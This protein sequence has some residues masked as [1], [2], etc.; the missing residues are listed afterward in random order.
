M[1]AFK[2]G[3]KDS[4]YETDLNQSAFAGG[5]LGADSLTVD[6]GGFLV[7]TQGHAVE[8]D[9]FGP[10]TLNI[11]GTVLST[12]PGF[13]GI[14]LTGSIS[15]VTANIGAEGF[16]SGASA[17]LLL[18]STGTQTITNAGTVEGGTYGIATIG[19]TTITNSGTISGGADAINVQN[20]AS[21]TIKN[22]GTIDGNL[23]LSA[24]GIHSVTNSN[25][26]VGDII[27]GI[28]DD[29]L[30]NSGNLNG[31]IHFATGNNKF[32]N[33]GEA[34][35]TINFG[36]GNDTLTNSGVL[37]GTAITLGGGKDVVTNSKHITGSVT[38]GSDDDKFT[39]TGTSSYLGAALI[40]GD[41]KNVVANGGNMALAITFGTGDDT[42]SNGKGAYLGGALTMSGG[43]NT[44]T[45]GG[46][47]SGAVTFGSGDDTFTNSGASSTSLGVVLGAGANKFTNAG[48]VNGT[49]SGGADVDTVS[50][51]ATGEIQTVDLSSGADTV[52]NAGEIGSLIMGS[53]NDIVVNTGEIDSVSL[54]DGDDK[55]TGGA[56]TDEV[57]D[58]NGADTIKL[59][60]GNDRY[61]SHGSTG[62]D[63]KLDTIDGGTGIDTYDAISVSTA[64]LINIDTVAHFESTISG[65]MLTVGNNSVEPI[66]FGLGTGTDD[67][68]F[69]FENVYGSAHNDVIYGNAA[70]NY[71]DGG[72]GHDGIAGFAG[73]DFLLGGG[74]NDKLLG[75]AGA[76]LLS[77]GADGD[78]YVYTALTDS[79]VGAAKRD[80]ILSF[81]DGSDGLEIYFDANT[82]DPGYQGFTYLNDFLGDVPFVNFT[83]TAGELRTLQTAAGYMVEGD[84]NGDAKAD[85]QI[86]VIDPSHSIT[87]NSAQ[88]FGPNVFYLY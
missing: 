41:G 58:S 1:T 27:F 45:N 18:Q 81:T 56:K 36:S 74:G 15:N 33:S 16:I 24:N 44:V 25:S 54:G 53:G 78:S 5:S 80:Q 32:T 85:F 29:T 82:Q 7:A 40:M 13:V 21:A 65:I 49:V 75:G 60:A 84:V 20:N 46:S 34:T 83:G 73:N 8:L 19:K 9:S 87:W 42:F 10:W 67:D 22:T 31:L 79:G 64:R 61:F 12:A 17:G 2:F 55:Y 70:V 69:N 71:I 43:K 6:L 86:L 47:I 88:N 57:G 39:N 51:A 52:T 48:E 14:A 30:T 76:D 63:D 72:A 68:I 35:G 26:I 37:D 4:I 62:F 28:K 77:G 11:N 59:G 23:T 66:T 3:T 38:F 50:N